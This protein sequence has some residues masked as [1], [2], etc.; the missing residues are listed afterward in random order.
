MYRICGGGVLTGIAY[1]MIK[2]LSFYLYVG[3]RDQT[4]AFGLSLQ[5]LQPGKASCR[6]VILI[7]VILSFFFSLRLF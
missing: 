7:T 2:V 4:E 3:S 1:I 6:P 5:D